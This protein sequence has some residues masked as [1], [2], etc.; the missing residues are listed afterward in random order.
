MTLVEEGGL[1]EAGP[2]RGAGTNAPSLCFS[3]PRTL[4]WGSLGRAPLEA[5]WARDLSKEGQGGNWK[6]SSAE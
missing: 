5:S 2:Q 6:D 1:P 4:C 3:C